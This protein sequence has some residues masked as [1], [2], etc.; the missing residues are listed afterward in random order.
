[1]SNDLEQTG[2]EPTPEE[3][4]LFA[5]ADQAAKNDLHNMQEA[6]K[7]MTTVTSALLAGAAA[8]YAQIHAPPAAK[9]LA[10][11]FFLLALGAALLGWLP[12]MRQLDVSCVEEIREARGRLMGRKLFFLRVSSLLLWLA[13]VA[14]AGGAA[15]AN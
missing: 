1:M 13:L 11:G 4:E 12:W 7:Q 8:F 5:W 15:L 6:L 14:F 9:L 2:R 10:A 3:A